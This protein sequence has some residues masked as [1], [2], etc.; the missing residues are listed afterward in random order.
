[1]QMKS[2]KITTILAILF[3]CLSV[4]LF[5]CF[6]WGYFQW[7]T[8][9]IDEI[10]YELTAP[11]EG[12]SSSI[13]LSFVRI[14]VLP[15]ALFI[16]VFVT[17]A[18]LLRKKEK[19]FRTFRR[20]SVLL[21]LILLLGTAAAA[22]KHFGVGPYLKGIVSDL[23]YIEDHY[24][25]PRDVEITFPEKKRNLI[26]LY[27]ESM[28]LS[29]ADYGHGGAFE[30][31]IIPDL[32]ELSLESE[33]FN[34]QESI[35][36][37]GH[38][39]YGAT[40]TMG[41][42]VAD[43]AGIPLQKDLLHDHPD[44]FY[45][46]VVTLS[47]ILKE[48][49]YRQEFL[50][51]SRAQFG[52]REQYLNSHGFDT[53]TDYDSLIEEG[54]LPSD[55]YVWWGFEDQKLFSYAKEKLLALSQ[56][57]EP[58]AFSLLTADTHTIGGYVCDL[59][60]NEYPDSYRNVIACSSKQVAEFVSWIKEQD[61][62]ENTTVIIVGDHPSMDPGIWKEEP[63]GYEHKV[64]TAI[65]NAAAEPAEPERFRN[66]TTMDFFPTT[67]SALGCTIEGDR[68]GLGTDLFSARDTLLEESD[69]KR[70]YTDLAGSYQYLNKL[71]GSSG[72]E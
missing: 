59:C 49:G 15:A 71:T 46:G 53:I 72:K 31:D 3:P 60:G 12:T 30:K 35:L 43:T 6:I 47:D 18:M 34:G 58:F 55:Y 7:G 2:G 33:S 64:Y 40:Y 57:G 13:L 25:D 50:M 11:L 20:I 56:S 5:F 10:V 17:A 19:A 52:G 66:Y 38:S 61:F 36:N 67:L 1:M 16:L 62:Y 63:E 68:L 29:Y 28:E 21:S 8:I 14:G 65:L 44:E 9:L 41:A 23:S 69:T 51:G 22:W 27:L 70:M 24:V 54:R 4:F 45:P 32:T 48:N 39:L 26:Y 37:G 42:I